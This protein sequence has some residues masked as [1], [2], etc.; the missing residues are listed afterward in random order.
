VEQFKNHAKLFQ[1][2]MIGRQIMDTRKLATFYNLART[3]NYSKTAEEIY[4]TQAT[5]SKHIMT[6]EKE[7]NVKL[8][9]REHRKV[10]LTKA[11]KA[12][13][14][15][16]REVLDK[17][18]QL[19]QRIEL[20]KNNA[21][22]TLV[23]KGVPSISQYSAFDTITQFTKQY[24]EINLKFSEAGTE[25]LTKVLNQDGTD[26]IFTRVFDQ[27]D[28][29]YDAIVNEYDYFVALV[30]QNNPLAQAKQLKVEDLKD[31]SFLLLEGTMHGSNPIIPML[32]KT[33]IQPRIMYE[34]Q[35]IDLILEM[36]NEGMG[37]SVVMDKSFDLTDYPNIVTIPI[38]PKK[39]SQLAFLKRKGPALPAV[40]LFW[41]F[42]KNQ[43]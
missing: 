8:F 33:D 22:K 26:I 28:E 32:K 29:K 41:K 3:K 13:L 10:E 17:E 43:L 23:I 30:P 16:V 6:L 12:L 15:E 25:K 2:G 24:P 20:L 35:R 27:I 39:V 7:W 42:A 1:K 11:G 4:L 38:T 36:L 9:S 5:V 31:E 34:G 14:P 19:T 40:D 18:H 21:K 37:V